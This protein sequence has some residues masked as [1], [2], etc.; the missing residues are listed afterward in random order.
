MLP[1]LRVLISRSLHKIG[2]NESEFVS[3]SVYKKVKL[4]NEK[5][6]KNKIIKL[7]AHIIRK[8]PIRKQC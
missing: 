8:I 7:K 5:F 2:F 6:I 4:S 3:Q 1:S